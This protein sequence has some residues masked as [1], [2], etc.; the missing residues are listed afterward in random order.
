LAWSDLGHTGLGRDRHGKSRQQQQAPM[1]SPLH[2]HPLN[3]QR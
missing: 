3:L 2:E 1:Q